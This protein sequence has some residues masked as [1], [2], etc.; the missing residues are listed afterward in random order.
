MLLEKK[1]G[2]KTGGKQKRQK[3]GRNDFFKKY[4]NVAHQVT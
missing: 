3:N 2:K 4:R 1:I